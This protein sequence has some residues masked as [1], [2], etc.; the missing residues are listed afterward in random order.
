VVWS[1]KIIEQKSGGFSSK[2]WDWLPDGKPTM[3]FFF[4]DLLRLISH[5]QLFWG[6]LMI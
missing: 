1:G 3:V 2:A 6:Y 5:K 4:W